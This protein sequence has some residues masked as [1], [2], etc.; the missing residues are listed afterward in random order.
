MSFNNYTLYVQ[1]GQHGILETAII[2]IRIIN[3]CYP[4]GSSARKD[5]LGG[6]GAVRGIWKYSVGAWNYKKNFFTTFFNPSNFIT[7]DS[8]IGT[9]SMDGKIPL[10]YTQSKLYNIIFK[11][12]V[13]C[14]RGGLNLK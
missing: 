13:S 11:H 4:K 3:C 10:K 14:V 2:I 12:K 8:I 5:P 7:Y 6:R 1:L 9:Y